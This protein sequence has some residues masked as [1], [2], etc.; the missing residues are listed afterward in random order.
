MFG[1][2]ARRIADLWRRRALCDSIDKAMPFQIA[3]LRSELWF[4]KSFCPINFREAQ[5]ESCLVFRLIGD[6]SKVLR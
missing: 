4:A 2:M 1:R 3:E 6:L 5:P